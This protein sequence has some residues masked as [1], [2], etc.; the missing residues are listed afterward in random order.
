MALTM[1]LVEIGES[2]YD[3]T[4]WLSSPGIRISVNPGHKALDIYNP[5]GFRNSTWQ[6]SSVQVWTQQQDIKLHCVFEQRLH[7][8]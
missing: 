5:S 2:R 8:T 4:K 6:T 1:D 7:N 3:H